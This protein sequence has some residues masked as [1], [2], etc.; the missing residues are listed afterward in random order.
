MVGTCNPFMKLT[1]FLLESPKIFRPKLP[2]NLT[3]QRV[4]TPEHGWLEYD[5]FL[6]GQDG[7]FSGAMF[8]L[9][10]GMVYTILHSSLGFT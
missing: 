9:V 10:S 1:K 4:E 3:E 6:L 5:C 8:M 7:L 2:S